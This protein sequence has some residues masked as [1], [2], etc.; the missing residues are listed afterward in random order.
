MTK[1]NLSAIKEQLQK[2]AMDIENPVEAAAPNGSPEAVMELV[3]DAIS[4][5][6]TAAEAIPA[7]DTR[8]QEPEGEPA[9]AP[10]KEPKKPAVAAAKKED[11]DE[12]EDKM[13]ELMAKIAALEEENTKIKKAKIAE[14]LVE[15]FPESVRQAKFDEIVSS[16]DSVDQLTRDL[17]TAKDVAESASTNA[18][19]NYVPA[20]SQS[21]YLNQLQKNA[22]Q[23]GNQL[24]A[25]KV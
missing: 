12:E 10:P 5:L 18:R 8:G 1:Q 7:D 13:S 24:P 21:G 25:W 11:E 15:Y 4:I 23:T 9:V 2:I 3:T 19:Q 22:K 6:E 20:T 14:E 17:K 16:K